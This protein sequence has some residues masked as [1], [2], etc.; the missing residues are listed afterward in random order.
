[1]CSSLSLSRSSALL[2]SMVFA[3][4]FVAM[5]INVADAAECAPEI[6]SGEIFETSAQSE[7][8]DQLPIEKEQ[9]KHGVCAHGHCH[10]GSVTADRAAYYDNSAI[11]TNDRFHVEA[12]QLA[13][14][15]QPFRLKRPPRA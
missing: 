13:I 11:L 4:M 7:T 10:N 15:A 8:T 1:M 5:G 12:D 14:S 6:S 2:R 3:I 9:S